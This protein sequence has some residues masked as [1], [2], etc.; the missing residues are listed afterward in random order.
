MTRIAHFI[1]GT[2]SP[3]QRF[4][5]KPPITHSF[6]NMQAVAILS[7]EAF[8]PCAD[9]FSNFIKE[10]NAGGF[11]A[12]K[13]WKN[14]DHYLE[15]KTGKGIWP[16]GNALDIFQQ[17]FHR[18]IKEARDGNRRKAAFFL[19]AAA[20]LVQDMCVPHHARG[21]MFSG[22]QEFESWAMEHC[23]LFSVDSLGLYRK[24]GAVTDYI[25]E[26]ARIA[27][28]MLDCVNRDKGNADYVKVTAVALPLAQ[29]STA[30]LFEQFHRIA[31]NPFTRFYLS[32]R[33]STASV[34]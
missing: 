7:N 11:W 22:H 24:E 33:S 18:S 14:V 10:I 15:P 23:Q 1:I 4:I 13:H 8:L 19:G 21:R 2:A 12:D 34:A 16:F 32:L 31:L 30:G 5:D 25:W 29:R 28:D 9:F 26:N 3:L 6:C 17:Y 27:A 20:H